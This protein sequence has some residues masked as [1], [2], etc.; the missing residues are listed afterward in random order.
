MAAKDTQLADHPRGLRSRCELLA[1]SGQVARDAPAPVRLL[2]FAMCVH[3]ACTVRMRYSSPVSLVWQAWTGA[4]PPQPLTKMLAASD[5][6][7]ASCA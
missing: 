5:T 1:M 6:F 2:V 4:R 7:F 3:V